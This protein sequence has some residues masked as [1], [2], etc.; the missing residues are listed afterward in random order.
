MLDTATVENIQAI[1]TNLSVQE[2]LELIRIIAEARLVVKPSKGTTKDEWRKKLRDEAAYWYARS[3]E[4]RQPYLGHI[5]AVQGHK[6]VDHDTDR[7][8][9]STRVRKNYPNTPVLLTEAETTA[10]PVFTIRSPRLERN[11]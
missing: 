10:P 6:V 7:H 9:L 8:A 11:L 4:E 3:D 2:R 5:V 1:A